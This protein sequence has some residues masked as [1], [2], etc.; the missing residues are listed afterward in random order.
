[1]TSNSSTTQHYDTIIIGAGQGGALARM[2]AQASQRVALVEA[3]HVGG[4]CVNVGCTP[5]KT[6]AYSARVAYLVGRSGDYGVRTG[7][8]RFD[9]Q[10]ARQR[11]RDIVLDFRQG[12]EKGLHAIENVHL[13]YG[14]AQFCGP[15]QI[16]VEL[17]AGG[18]CTLE[19]KTIVIAAGTRFALPPVAG[20]AEV[21]YLDSTSIMELGE[22]PSHLLILGGGYIAV[23]FGQM[24]RR[25]GAQVTLIEVGHQLL[26]REDADIA[27]AATKILREDGLDI[28][29]NSKAKQARR[30]EDGQI[31]LV[32]QA[33]AG[34]QT[35]RGSHLLVAAGRKPNT[36]TLNVAAA[37]VALDDKGYVQV[38]EKLETNMPGIYA[39]GDIKGGPAFTHIA[40]DD[41][42]ILCANLG[43]GHDAT[44]HN[45]LVPYTVFIDPQLGRI[46][47]TE[48]EARAQGYKVRVASLTMDQTARGSET[49]ETRGLWKV[50]V[51]DATNQILGGAFLSIE[52]GEIAT[53]VQVAMMGHLPYTALRDGTFSHPTLSESLNN[54]FLAMDRVH[55]PGKQE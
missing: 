15:K 49:G 39:L 50:V 9:I 44:I 40:Y 8:T 51:D 34:E 10:V 28:H 13:L 22:V 32:V 20:L 36:D 4:T 54:L 2:L 27:E 16:K 31:E 30:T 45:R 3:A 41:A 11:K 37:G 35:L 19:A 5:T 42:R 23:E 26:A 24:F 38:N 17:N 47:L 18:E 55:K 43:E 46:G 25:F 48:Q 1:M 29:L 52:G 14:K 53:T 12:V 6:L 21:P 7:P 33:E